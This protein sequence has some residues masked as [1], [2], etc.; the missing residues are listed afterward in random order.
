MNEEF[1]IGT[2]SYPT[3]LTEE[4]KNNCFTCNGEHS[5]DKH[6]GLP[7]S[8]DEVFPDDVSERE[9]E[10]YGDQLE[11]LEQKL[12]DILTFMARLTP[13]VE[14]AE[15]MLV[16]TSKKDKLKLFMGMGND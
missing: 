6:H 14:F 8:V 12:D 3:P 1:Q 9:E 15:K 11:A 5:W 2:A 4:E 16:T 13:L 7:D 10:S